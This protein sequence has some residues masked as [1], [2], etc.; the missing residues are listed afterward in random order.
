MT[1][2]DLF[3]WVPP[4]IMGDRDGYTYDPARDRARLDG[5]A[6][7]VWR[8]MADGLW[9][10]PEAIEAATGHNWAAAGARLRDFRKPSFGGHT[11]ERMSCGKG[12][13]AYRLI[14]N[15]KA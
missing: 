5:Q 6:G 10:T 15:V 13:F 14:P 1:T 11:V 8:F 7:A 2:L 9:H 12:L 3:S 4:Q